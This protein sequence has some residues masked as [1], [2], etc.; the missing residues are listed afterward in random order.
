MELPAAL[1]SLFAPGVTDVMFIGARHCFLDQAGQ[2]RKVSSPFSSDTEL[3]QLL[4]ELALESGS[5]LD[6]AKPLSDFGFGNFR[7]S[8]QLKS[9]IT[10]VP[11]VTIRRHP[12]TA[13]T[14]E[15]LLAAK[16]LTQTQLEFIEVM[17]AEGKTFL[18]SGPTS[19]G[20][21]TLL[22]AMIRASG[23]R[24]VV[25]EQTPELVTDP[26]SVR[27]T[28]RANNQQGV[29]LI[30]QSELL[31]AALRMR[32]DRLAIGEVR[33]EEFLALLQAI[34]NGHPALATIHARE[35]QDLPNRLLLLGQLAAVEGELVAR[36]CQA[37]DY[38][39]QIELLGGT[40][41]VSKVAKFAL[42]PEF[43]VS[44]VEI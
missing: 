9:A 23:Q 22:G 17:L 41:K 37:I 32:P 43:G 18:I 5:R 39:I 6:L 7:F 30:S 16:F 27:L 34:N 35:L 33:G 29:G 25:V 44:E 8:A 19:A 12:K 14:L 28:E 24:V 21:T 4:I 1:E 11:C 20:K 2:L 31:S 15:H 26:P 10:D 13:I 3:S 36:L 40:R 38:V 42:T